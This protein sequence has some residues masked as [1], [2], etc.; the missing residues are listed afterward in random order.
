MKKKYLILKFANRNHNLF[1]R[2]FFG[3]GFFLITLISTK[4]IACAKLSFSDFHKDDFKLG[5]RRALKFLN[6]Y[7][8]ITILKDNTFNFCEEMSL[9]AINVIKKKFDKTTSKEFDFKKKGQYLYVLGWLIESDKKKKTELIKEFNKYGQEIIN[10]GNYIYS[11]EEQDNLSSEENKTKERKRKGDFVITE[12]I[13]AL[14]DWSRMF[15]IN[16]YKWFVISGTFLGLI[17]EGGFLKHD[18]D[19]DIGIDSEDYNHNVVI[20]KISKSKKFFIRKIDFLR[21]GFFKKD[22]YL[23]KEKRIVLV[24]L[25]HKSGLNIDLFV[26]YRENNIYWHGSSFHRWDNH[27]FNLKNY[28]LHGIDVLGPENYD[29]YLT[30]NYG[31]WRTPVKDFHF[32]TGTPNLSINTNPSSIAMFLKR[33][34]EFR[35]AKSFLKNKYILYRCN[36][37]SDDGV[38]D[39]SNI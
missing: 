13:K 27:I 14:Y 11:N 10:L 8:G 24:K 3:T 29:L 31:N 7:W 21:E 28:N 5:I 26:H 36:I 16:K 23:T 37:L 9:E 2:Y 22:K 12:A 38:F 4:S 32:N 1:L 15:P 35:S 30:E 34:S 19:I 6:L 18:Y 25:I 20:N 17:R 33:M 39:I